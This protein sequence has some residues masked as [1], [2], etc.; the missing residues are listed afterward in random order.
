MSPDSQGS[1]Y[2]NAYG[3]CSEPHKLPV[4][5]LL[6][7]RGKSKVKLSKVRPRQAKGA[8]KVKV[9]SHKLLFSPSAF[10]GRISTNETRLGRLSCSGSDYRDARVEDG[11]DLVR[12]IDDPPEDLPTELHTWASGVSLFERSRWR[13]RKPNL[14]SDSSRP[15]CL[16]PL[17]GLSAPI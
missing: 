6:A 8:I 10:R 4:N 7:T 14:A 1:L 16:C 17:P 3:R 2:C 9:S 15:T 12:D 13:K 5:K 11:D